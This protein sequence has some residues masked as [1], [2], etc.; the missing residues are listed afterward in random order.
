MK[1]KFPD[2]SRND[3]AAETLKRLAGEALNL[4]DEHWLELKPFFNWSS[5]TWSDAVSL[6]SRHVDFQRNVRTFPAFISDLLCIL[7]QPA[8]AN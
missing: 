6:A 2:D 7:Q 5:S 4:S 3:E 1:T 8:T